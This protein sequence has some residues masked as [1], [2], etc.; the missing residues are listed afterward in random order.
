ML[1]QVKLLWLGRGATHMVGGMGCLSR[2]H[3]Q[4]QQPGP[5]PA[6][7]TPLHFCRWLCG[8]GGPSAKPRHP[9][10]SLTT[11]LLPSS[12]VRFRALLRPLLSWCCSARAGY[13][14][15]LGRPCMWAAL[16]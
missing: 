14:L 6:A 1:G 12:R 15:S 11:C 2:V 4:L 13:K 3:S 9:M 5:L 8:M 16:V 7:N 10:K